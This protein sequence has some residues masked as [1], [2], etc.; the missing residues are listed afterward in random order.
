MKTLRIVL[1]LDYHATL[2]GSEDG[3]A[4]VEVRQG[5]KAK[6]GQGEIK[7]IGYKLSSRKKL[8]IKVKFEKKS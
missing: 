2:L 4:V 6:G 5:K 3:E 1:P 7:E 8:G